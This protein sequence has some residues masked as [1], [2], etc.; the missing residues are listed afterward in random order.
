MPI[1][2]LYSRRRKR[3]FQKEPD[4][5]MYDVVPEILRG[6]VTH[7]W[8]SA[9]GNYEGDDRLLTGRNVHWDFIHKTICREKGVECLR[10]NGINPMEDCISYLKSEENVDLW[11]D[12]VEISFWLLSENPD[13]Y[14][15]HQ[16]HSFGIF[17]SADEALDELNERFR[18][19]AFGYRFESG[20][21]IRI[22][23]EFVHSEIVKP[24]LL[25]LSDQRFK[26]AQDE[27]LAAHE[28]YRSGRNTEAV[29]NANSAFESTMKIICDIRGWKYQGDRATDLIKTIRARGLLPDYLNA[30]FDQLIAAMKSGL[31]TVRNK[32]GGH[33]KGN[34]P[35]TPQHIAAYAL[36]LA[37]A[38][39]VLLVESFQAIEERPSYR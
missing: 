38:N 3:E 23:S 5:Y 37:A 25:L 24:S 28:H 15:A 29:T 12:I 18:L 39:I 20:R 9:I 6:Q 34:A 8:K 10:L 33:G 16:S 19:A 26:T 32:A 22:D 17:Q 7:I 4:V 2:D 27:Y 1:Y 31:P 36:H 14:S 35:E 11:L 13:I 21:I 30:S